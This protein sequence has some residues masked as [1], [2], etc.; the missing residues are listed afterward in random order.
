[1]VAISIGI[2]NYA[3]G[4][5]NCFRKKYGNI[6]LLAKTKLSP[7]DVLLARAL[8]DS[9]IGCDEFVL[10]NNALREYDNMKK[11]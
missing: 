11:K 10:L 4:L 9:Y 5:K 8:I 2:K 6:A 3:I 1:M 7:I